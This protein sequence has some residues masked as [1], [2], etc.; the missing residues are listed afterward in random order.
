MLTN[1]L[2]S[3]LTEA[4]C[5]CS[6]RIGMQ[7]TSKNPVKQ[8]QRNKAIQEG[9]LTYVNIACSF[10]FNAALTMEI[11]RR[12]AYNDADRLNEIDF[13]QIMP[14]DRSNRPL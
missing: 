7:S 14:I 6:N 2:Y 13:W 12:S 1:S 8:E 10:M 9:Y 5:L 3:I 11:L 4:Q